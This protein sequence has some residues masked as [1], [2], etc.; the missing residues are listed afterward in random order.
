MV[1]QLKMH[2]FYKNE[3]FKNIVA[4]KSWKLRITADFRLTFA[5]STQY[6]LFCLSLLLFNDK[7]KHKKLSVFL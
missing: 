4:Q 1:D 3:V 7:V 2:S 5:L 6:L